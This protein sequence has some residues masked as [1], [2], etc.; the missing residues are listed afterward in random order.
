MPLWPLKTTFFVRKDGN[1]EKW[2]VD[3][4]GDIHGKVASSKS[5]ALGMALLRSKKGVTITIRNKEGGV[6]CYKVIAIIPPTDDQVGII[7]KKI[8]SGA[9]LSKNEKQLLEQQRLFSLLALYYERQY[10][11]TRDTFAAINASKYWRKQGEPEHAL[12]ITGGIE[13]KDSYRMSMVLTTRGGAFKDRG[14]LVEAEECARKAIRL[15]KESYHPWNLLGA[16]Y[17]Q[18]GEPKE[19][20]KCFNK[21]EELGAKPRDKETAIRSAVQRAG[22][23]ERQKVKLYLQQVHPKLYGKFRKYLGRS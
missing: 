12:K 15:D 14:A 16:V 7:L 4:Q 11:T 18:Q 22:D 21:A 5:S 10:N 20:S 23:T 8:E 6:E 17:Y 9:H 19:G 2:I 1:D 3:V 13:D